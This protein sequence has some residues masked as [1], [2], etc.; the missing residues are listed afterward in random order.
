MECFIRAI[1]PVMR[2]YEYLG[3]SE[4]P[5]QV[6]SGR[7]GHESRRNDELL[8]FDDSNARNSH[9]RRDPEIRGRTRRIE[10]RI[11]CRARGA[12][13]PRAVSDSTAP[14]VPNPSL[15][16]LPAANSTTAQLAIR[17]NARCS[18]RASPEGTS[19]GPAGNVRQFFAIANQHMRLGTQ[20]PDA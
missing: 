8:H 2:G 13:S 4:S 19:V 12:C 5:P 6:L 9:N 20:A 3:S 1:S 18:R 15:P 7:A 17:R 10:G 14:V 16:K 11:A